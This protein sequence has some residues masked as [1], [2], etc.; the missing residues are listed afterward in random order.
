MTTITA[1]SDVTPVRRE[2]ATSFRRILNVVRLH[3]GNPYTTIVLPWII[4]GII[5]AI[6]LVIWALIA[7]GTHGQDAADASK[8][9]SYSGSSFYI[10]VYMMIVAVQAVS[11]TFPF[12]LSYGATRRDYWLGTSLTFVLLS[13]MYAIGFTIL[14]VIERATNG[15]GLGG[16]MFTPIYF[17][18]TW[19]Q[20]LLICF[21]GLLF[22]FFVGSSLAAVW[23]RW[24]ATGMVVFF[25]TVAA[26][27]LGGIAWLTL[28]NSWIGFWTALAAAGPLG[29]ASWLLVPAAIG[30]VVGYFILRRATPRS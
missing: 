6:N 13:A 18:D 24:K 21:F 11:I 8:G 25:T 5:L 17:G 15:W 2:G 3:L 4:L 12:A 7:I 14:G 1:T 22:F 20:R 23:V 30:A 9:F 29:I 10:A 27:L 26:L 19:L 28:S 16:R